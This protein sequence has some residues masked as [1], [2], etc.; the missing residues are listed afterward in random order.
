[1]KLMRRSSDGAKFIEI[2]CQKSEAISLDSKN[3]FA[4]ESH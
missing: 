3:R 2:K 4:L 1:M